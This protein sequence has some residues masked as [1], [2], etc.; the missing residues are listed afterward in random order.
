[1]LLSTSTLGTQPCNLKPVRFTK[2][3]FECRVVG[4]EQ[5]ILLTL[6]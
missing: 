4:D 1:V 5:S 6:S 2:Q 3:M